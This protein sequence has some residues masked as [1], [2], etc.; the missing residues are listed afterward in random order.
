MTPMSKFLI[1]VLKIYNRNN[2]KELLQK[3]HTPIT[4]EFNGHFLINFAKNG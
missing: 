3:P 4:M 2:K 1:F